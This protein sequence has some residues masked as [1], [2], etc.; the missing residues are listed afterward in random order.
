MEKDP[1]PSL[2][3]HRRVTSR[4]LKAACSLLE[5]LNGLATTYF[6]YYLYFYTEE[7]FH[8]HAMQNLLLAALLGAV[9][10]FGAFFSGRFAQSFGYFTAIRCGVVLMIVAFLGCSQTGSMGLTIAL[11]VVGCIGMC[12]TWPAME[13]LVSE[14]EPP[15]RLQGLVGLYNFVWAAA[16]G[17][18]Y[19][20]GG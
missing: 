4:N 8:F 10:A 1:S 16:A 20:T 15:A 5:G 9:Y 14:G 17:F 7:R 2:P 3:V 11:A 6:F 19:F 18:A 12:W 13:A